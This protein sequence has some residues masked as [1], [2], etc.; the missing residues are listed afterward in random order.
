VEKQNSR[1]VTSALRG[2]FRDD[3]RTREE[4]MR[5]TNGH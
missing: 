4:F 2:A 5:L 3:S 1:T